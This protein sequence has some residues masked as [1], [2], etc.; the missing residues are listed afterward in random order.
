M[1]F[2]TLK[3]SSE[4]GEL[5]LIDGGFCHW[6]LRRDGQLTIREIISTKP[7]A[8]SQMLNRLKYTVGATSLYAKCPM[9]L[10]ANAWYSRKGFHVEKIETTPSGRRL[11]CWRLN[12]AWKPSR[13]IGNHIELIY[14]AANAPEYMKSAIDAGWLPGAQLPGTIYYRPYFVDQNY[15]DPNAWEKYLPAVIRWQP[16]M[17]T[18]TDWEY[19][20]TRDEILRRAE[21]IA[22]HCQ[23][24]VII[25][26]IPGTIDQIPETVSGKPVRLGYSVP[27]SHGSTPVDIAEF[28]SRPVHLLGGD[29]RKQIDLTQYMN[30]VSADTNYHQERAVNG[31]QFMAYH[32]VKSARRPEWPTLKEAGLCIP[33]MEGNQTAMKLSFRAIREMWIRYF[34][35][36]TVQKK[37]APPYTLKMAI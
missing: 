36:H 7:G 2:E 31:G 6:H 28:G 10:P 1:I 29:P 20:Y 30:V 8:G 4:R 21:Q 27:T 15:H 23:V 5:M 11:I 35:S 33:K 37:A 16:Y 12:L 9:D 32:P 34:Q 14:C 18:I 13:N 3:E 22:P 26:K 17:A 19:G 25:P 24:I